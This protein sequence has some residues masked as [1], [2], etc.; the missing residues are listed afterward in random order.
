MHFD[1][2]I[3]QVSKTEEIIMNRTNKKIVNFSA[4]CHICIGLLL[5]IV[6]CRAPLIVLNSSSILYPSAPLVDLIDLAWASGEHFEN[7][8]TCNNS[9]N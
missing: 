9:C 6:L 8:P 7:K 4:A 2:K 3:S 5:K 1:V